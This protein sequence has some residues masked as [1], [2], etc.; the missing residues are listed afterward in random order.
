MKRKNTRIKFC[1]V[2]IDEKKVAEQIIAPPGERSKYLR[3]TEGET[4]RGVA[5]PR[6][7]TSEAS[8]HGEPGGHLAQ[9]GHDEEDDETDDGV[10]DED[11]AG[12]GLRQGLPGADD[13]T[14]P[15]GTADGNHRDVARLE[16]AVQGRLARRLQTADVDVLEVIVALLLLVE[17]PFLRGRR[18]VDDPGVVHGW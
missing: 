18:P 1:L 17:A 12:A 2:E 14:C 5:E 13:Q 9:G 10:R 11:G 6:S 8:G 16:A 7:V 3:P 4:K 15:E